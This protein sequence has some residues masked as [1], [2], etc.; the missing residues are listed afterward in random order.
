MDNITLMFTAS[1]I[2]EFV[3]EITFLLIIMFLFVF[4]IN[5]IYKKLLRVSKVVKVCKSNN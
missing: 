1:A 3:F 2:V 5:K 4:R